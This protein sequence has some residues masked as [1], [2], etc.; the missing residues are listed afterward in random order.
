MDKKELLKVLSKPLT[1]LNNLI[2]K[3]KNSIFIYSNLG[4]RDNVKSL[5]DYLISQHYNDNYTIVC[6]LDDYQSYSSEPPKNVKF[7]SNMGGLPY[8]LTSEYAF[9]SFGKYPIKPSSKQVVVNLWHGMP[10]KTVGNLVKGFENVD[11]NYFTYTIATSPMFAEVMSRSFNCPLSNVLLTG[12]PRCDI[13][14]NSQVPTEKLILWLPTY[15]ISDR[16]NSSDVQLNHGFDFPL[17]E[18]ISQLGILNQLLSKLGY[19][20]V[21]KPHPMQNVTMHLEEYSN[22]KIM[23]QQDYDKQNITIYDTF[24]RSSALITDYSSVYFDYLL[25]NKPVAFTVDDITSY[26]NSRGFSVDNPQSLMAGSKL[27]TFENLLEYIQNVA[28]GVDNFSDERV[29]VNSLVNSHQSKCACKDILT[30][31]GINYN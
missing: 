22:I 30:H 3:R 5:Y 24:L 16:L 21:I 27:T 26:S 20:L 8:F 15:R 2:P 17:I 18:N 31:I 14:L 4:F 29:R 13:L 10:L 11:Y 23:S 1:P 6:S 28:K 25:L 9:Y 7:V 12:Q 19:T